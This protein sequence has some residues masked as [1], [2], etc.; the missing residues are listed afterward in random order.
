[1]AR[2]RHVRS[3]LQACSTVLYRMKVT[4]HDVHGGSTVT[5]HKHHLGTCTSQRDG[6]PH[7]TR[8]I[9]S[10]SF[11]ACWPGGSPTNLT[12][13]ATHGLLA[14]IMLASI[15][16]ASSSSWSHFTAH[17]VPEH[18]AARV[19]CHILAD[20]PFQLLCTC[21]QV[22]FETFGRSASLKECGAMKSAALISLLIGL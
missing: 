12:M 4:W 20:S 6:R 5:L 7:F 10:S 3:A 11:T 21:I 15:C 1:M 19:S 2:H 13:R 14:V 16:A 18:M 8:K 22:T 17:D 9:D